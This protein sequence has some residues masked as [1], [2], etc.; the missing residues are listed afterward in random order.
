MSRILAVDDEKLMTE[1]YEALFSEAGYE[2]KTAPDAAAAMEL[3]YD[4]KPD[5]LVLDAEMPGGGGERVFGI[6]RKLL[7]SGVPVVFVTGL[8]E[9]VVDFALTQSRVRVFKKPVAPA[10]LLSAVEE[11]LEPKG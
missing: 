1:L 11:L 10:E 2:V 6:T 7:G 3:F 8:P 9:R 5:L 4:F